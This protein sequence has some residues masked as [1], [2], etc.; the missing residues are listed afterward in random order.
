MRERER[1]REREIIIYQWTGFL[2]HDK[3]ESIKTG[4]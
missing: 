1:E 3:L 4:Q 2:F